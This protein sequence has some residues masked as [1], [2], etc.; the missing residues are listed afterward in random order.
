L[1][2]ARNGLGA[3]VKAAAVGGLLLG[4]IEGMSLWLQRMAQPPPPPPPMMDAPLPDLP[5][6]G[7][8]GGGGA[9]D[10]YEYGGNSY[11]NEEWEFALLCVCGCVFDRI[12]HTRLECN[13]QHPKKQPTAEKKT[14]EK[15]PTSENDVRLWFQSVF[16]LV[17]SSVLFFSLRENKQPHQHIHTT[18]T[19]EKS[20]ATFH[21]VLPATCLGCVFVVGSSLLSLRFGLP[22]ISC[23]SALVKHDP[24]KEGWE[25][26]EAPIA[27][28]TCLGDNAFVRMVCFCLLGFPVSFW[29]ATVLEIVCFFGIISKTLVLSLSLF[30][31]AVVFVDVAALVCVCA[32]V[33]IVDAKGVWRSL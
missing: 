23:M 16:L 21:G 29:F 10:D 31:G 2:A 26:A 1:L 28:G 5:T 13:I 14:S 30:Y 4:L 32:C 24:T 11:E 27:C 18:N 19:H 3:S 25:S 20:F 7:A 8:A 22:L 33:C 6:G 17:G 12:P 9:S 15:T